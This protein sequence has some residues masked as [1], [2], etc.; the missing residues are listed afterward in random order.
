MRLTAVPR[1]MPMAVPSSSM[2]MRMSRKRLTSTAW[3]VVSGHWVKLSP[4]KMTRPML[5]LGRPAMNCV[6]TSLAA[7]R[8]LGLKS[9]A[10]IL[11]EMSMAITMSM[12]SVVSLWMR[13]DDCGRASTHIT[14][15]NASIRKIIGT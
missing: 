1:P 11:P 8:R 4:E 12:P 9:S 7:S 3:S 10:S 14:A 5:S 15:A 2:P 6:A 13:F